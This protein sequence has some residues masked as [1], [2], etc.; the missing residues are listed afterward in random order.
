MRAQIEAI[1]PA[2]PARLY[3]AADGPR[4]NRPDEAAKCAAVRDCAKLVD[5]PCEVKTLFSPKNNGCQMGPVT[6]IT[7]FFE[8]EESGIVL[9]DDCR[10]GSEFLRFAT[11]MLKRYADVE[12]V[13]LIAGFNEFN[14]Q[15]DTTVSYHFSEH[16]AIW[17][18]ASWRRV[19][20]KY[21]VS[22]EKYINRAEQLIDES[23]MLPY[24]K[25]FLRKGLDE[26]RHGLDA[27]DFPF[28]LM[29]LAERYLSIKPVVNL[30]SNEGVRKEDATH[31]GGYNYYASRFARRYALKFPLVHP[32]EIVCDEWADRRREQMEGA[33]LP[34]GLTWLGSKVPRL[35]P[36]LTAIGRV[37]E[38]LAP[39]L[40]RWP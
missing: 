14:L 40:M 7:W 27:W 37:I 39:I 11:E 2:R 29:F 18:W 26:V 24:G 22:M 9:E 36:L 19:W 8:N 4:E 3:I 21:D 17:G 16:L 28:S 35:C 5:W 23:K 1:R 34:R 10:P 12:Q 25:M 30:I 20:Q 33:I 31:T 15:E 38:R 32:A 6:A 13:G